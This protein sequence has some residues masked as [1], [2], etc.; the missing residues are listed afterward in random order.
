MEKS[1][2]GPAAV[3]SPV[4]IASLPQLAF[5]DLID[6]VRVS[7]SSMDFVPDSYLASLCSVVVYSDEFGVAIGGDLL[8]DSVCSF[9]QRLSD[10]NDPVPGT[11]QGGDNVVHFFV[12]SRG[13]VG[14]VSTV[15]FG[16]RR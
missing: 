13:V 9:R 4:V 16:H 12:S 1:R 7:E 3:R 6:G 5:S 2:E 10:P 15:D 14:V 8:A 11:S